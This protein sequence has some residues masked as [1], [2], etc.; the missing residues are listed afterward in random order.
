MKLSPL[1]FVLLSLSDQCN[2][3]VVTLEVLLSLLCRPA[4]YLLPLSAP[5]L[6]SSLCPLF[7]PS[8][9]SS[10]LPCSAHTPLFHCSRYIDSDD[11]CCLKFDGQ[12]YIRFLTELIYKHA[13]LI[14]S[15]WD[16]CTFLQPS[17]PFL[18]FYAHAFLLSVIFHAHAVNLW[19]W[20][21][22]N[23]ELDWKI[24][25]ETF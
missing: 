24:F 7:S 22:W 16:C 21:I 5:P 25:C 15:Q 8:V 17:V 6:H 20:T 11:G 18:S 3:L 1:L 9:L 14:F 10:L 2:S 19:I 4:Q 13:R 23:N 12:W